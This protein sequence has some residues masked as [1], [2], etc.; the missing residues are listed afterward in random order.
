[1]TKKLVALVLLASLTLMTGCFTTFGA[2]AGAKSEKSGGP[3]YSAGRGAL[4]GAVIDA[5][6]IGVVISQVK[7]DFFWKKFPD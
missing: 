5:V 2:V 1:M 7:D 6:I 3:P 4:M